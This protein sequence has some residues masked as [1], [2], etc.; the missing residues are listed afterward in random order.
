MSKVA[1]METYL[2]RSVTGFLGRG[3]TSPRTRDCEFHSL[4]SQR[5]KLGKPKHMP[6]QGAA[7]GRKGIILFKGSIGGQTGWVDLWNGAWSA[8]ALQ[9]VV[10]FVE[11]IVLSISVQVLTPRAPRTTGPRAVWTCTSGRCKWGLQSCR[12]ATALGW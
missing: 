8:D 2:V 11:S 9:Q 3:C 12:G 5:D 1:S 4:P 7:A 6:D 10:T